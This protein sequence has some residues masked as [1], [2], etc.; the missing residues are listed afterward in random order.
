MESLRSL[1][2]T[3]KWLDFRDVLSCSLV[4]TLYHKAATTDEVWSGLCVHHCIDD[5]ACPHPS[6]LVIFQLSIIRASTVFLVFPKRYC[7]F[8]CREGR[9]KTGEVETARVGWNT[10]WVVAE[11]GVLISGGGSPSTK[12]AWVLSQKTG[13]VR[14]VASMCRI[15]AGHGLAYH[16]GR[17]FAFGGAS[18]GATC[19]K[20][21]NEAWT[22]LRNMHSVH[23]WFTPAVHL[24]KVYL[25]GGSTQVCEEF[26]T[27]TELCASLPFLLPQTSEACACWNGEKLIVI[28]RSTATEI[29]GNEVRRIVNRVEWGSSWTN[30]SPVVAGNYVYLPRQSDHCVRKFSL[31]SLSEVKVMMSPKNKLDL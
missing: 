12:E 30:M 9:W 10:S 18:A 20:Y 3:L 13:T 17:V 14:E 8:H 22:E 7:S 25:C 27:Q 11:E 1:I 6:S 16:S 26:S 5:L 15:R 21:A 29:E 19:E 31:E 4:S 24:C 23:S 2:E 28:Q